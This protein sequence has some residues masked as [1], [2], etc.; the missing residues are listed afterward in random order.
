MNLSIRLVLLT[1]A[2]G[3]LVLANATEEISEDRD[4]KQLDLTAWNCVNR[5]EGTG[6]SPETAE[7]NRLKNR[8]AGDLSNL[9]VTSFDTSSFLKHVADFDAQTK[10]KRRKDLN[11]DEKRRLEGLE[12]PL[13]SFTG[14]L[15]LAYAGPTESTNCGSL[16]FHDW[17][18][19]IFDEPADHPPQPGDPT[20]IICEITP[21]TQNAI[22]HDGIRVQ[23]L[24][25]FFRRPDLTYESTG[26][27]AQ[28]IRVTGYLLWDDEHND[29]TKDV[30]TTIRSIARNKYHNPWRATAWEIHP[31][32]KIERADGTGPQVSSSAAPATAQR[33]VT[34]LRAVKIKIPSGKTVLQRGMRLPIVSQ[35]A[36]TVTVRYLDGT[37]SIPIASTDLR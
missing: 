10:S 4:L 34:V 31:V 25:A 19:E 21:R 12:A 37:Y 23:E 17:H 30:G 27:K 9:A 35:D 28:K 2:P 8:F 6:Q 32:I 18:L 16:D 36:T 26:H 7:R 24:A 13:V 11:A 15:V 14:Y 29:N 5:P 33:Y 3:L 1:L 22:Y 20:P